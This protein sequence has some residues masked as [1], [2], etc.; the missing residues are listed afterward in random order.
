MLGK[1]NYLADAL[2]TA[3]CFMVVAALLT[4]LLVYK[5]TRI[6]RDEMSALVATFM[7]AIMPAHVIMAQQMRP[8]EIAAL[9]VALQ[10]YLAAK[11]MKTGQERTARTLLWLSA[12]LGG[13]MLAY[14]FPLLLFAGMPMLAWLLRVQTGFWRH[15]LRRIFP[16]I[17][18]V[19]LLLIVTGYVIGS[20]QTFSHFDIFMDG[21][22]IQ[23]S[24]QSSPFADAV[25]RGPIAFQYW[26][27][28][29]HQALGYPLYFVAVAGVVLLLGR[30]LPSDWLL[31]GGLLPYMVMVSLTSWVVVRY[32][33]PLLPLFAVAIAEIIMVAS[34]RFDIRVLA[35]AM[36]TA[37]LLTLWA[38]FAF[39][40][41]EAAPNV[42]E[43]TQQWIDE[44]VPR[45]Q[46]IL[47]VKAYDAEDMYN[48]EFNYTRCNGVTT[49]G[50]APDF[51]AVFANKS[52][53]YVLLHEHHYANME[54]LGAAHPDPRSSSFSRAMQAAGFTEF[55]EIKFRPVLFGADFSSWFT[56]LDMTYVN[57][58]F[59][60]Y[61]RPAKAVE[62]AAK[63]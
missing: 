29:L 57:P 2:L 24:F 44:I 30:R 62:A 51:A 61:Q 11:I 59:R 19:C 27:G 60:L 50:D 58:G 26:W 8:D 34:R 14:R 3:R 36:A 46:C 43:F 37:V 42:R 6:L 21:M 4:M 25:G 12:I 55:R 9:L 1:Y 16:T 56:S 17:V 54:R 38:V 7:L 53:V 31:L 49:L 39:L 20:P 5:G 63:G 22:G 13:L 35:P 10:Y 23:W 45:N 52:I 48:P 40:R 47:M 18:P 33:L 15:A 41:M 32:T 28:M